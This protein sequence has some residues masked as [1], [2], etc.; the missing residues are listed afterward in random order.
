[1]A[2]YI[3]AA[4]A[5]DWGVVATSPVK[6]DVGHLREAEVRRAHRWRRRPQTADVHSCSQLR[7]LGEETQQRARTSLTHMRPCTPADCSAAATVE[8]LLALLRQVADAAAALWLPASLREQLDGALGRPPR[9]PQPQPPPPPEPSPPAPPVETA[10]A[11]VQCDIIMAPVAPKRMTRSSSQRRAKREA[12][13]ASPDADPGSPASPASPCPASPASPP[14]PEMTAP[15]KKPEALETAPAPDAAVKADSATF[16][17]DS[18]HAAEQRR[19]NEAAAAAGDQSPRTR[20]ARGRSRKGTVMHLGDRRLILQDATLADDVAQLSQEDAAPQSPLTQAKAANRWK[21]ISMRLAEA[22]VQTVLQSITLQGGEPVHRVVLTGGPCAGKSTGMAMLRSALEKNGINVFCVPEAAT[23]LIGGGC[24]VIFKDCDDDKL[25]RFQLALLETQM[26]LEDAFFAIAKAT[27]KKGVV[28]CDRG[29]MDGRAFCSEQLWEKILREGD[30]STQELRDG[31]YDMVVHLVTAA[32]GAQQFYGTENNAARSET[33]EQAIAQDR[34]LQK[35]WTGHPKIRIVDNSTGFSEKMERVIMPILE[36]VGIDRRPGT[37]RKYRVDTN[38]TPQDIPKDVH[39]EKSEVL[40]NFLRGSRPGNVLRLF[41]RS[42]SGDG[43]K[44]VTATG[45]RAYATYVLQ[46]F[47][48]HEGQMLREESSLSWNAYHAMQNSQV[49]ENMNRILRNVY[50]FVYANQY[51]EIGVYAEP[52]HSAG[53]TYLWVETQ[54]DPQ[55]NP[56]PVQLP[57]WVEDLGLEDVTH[58][59]EDTDFQQAQGG[60]AALVQAAKNLKRGPSNRRVI[61]TESG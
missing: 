9:H 2:S 24:G 41:Q 33:A 21:D 15:A 36:L 37:M 7:P 23:I 20:A 1:M 54:R 27:Q 47:R 6:V 45:D 43:Q 35:M 39:I 49:D 53:M 56:L 14:E 34:N 16:A 50:S 8:K 60:I 59:G 42:D 4:A 29:A 38:F 5:C 11:E 3:E 32:D 52:Q 28:I 10:H 22:K 48:T 31:R 44:K 26:A 12:A 13:D 19:A 40:I 17:P 18:P 61:P 51:F 46:K 25:F 57:Q 55:G 58:E 30:W